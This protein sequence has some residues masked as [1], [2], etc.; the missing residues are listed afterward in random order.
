MAHADAGRGLIL[1]V[2]AG[3]QRPQSVRHVEE[4][5]LLHHPS[6]PSRDEESESGRRCEG[7]RFLDASNFTQNY[8]SQ[9]RRDQP[10][11]NVIFYDVV[12]NLH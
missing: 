10:T 9:I 7:E 5:R 8:E 11:E 12:Q 2:A 4:P 1:P 3:G 6:D